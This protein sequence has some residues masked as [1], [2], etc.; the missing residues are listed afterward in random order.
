MLN[1]C[2]AI[3]MRLLC[4]L[5]QIISRQHVSLYFPKNNEICLLDN[6]SSSPS[7]LSEN[8]QFHHCNGVIA[9]RAMHYVNC[10]QTGLCHSFRFNCDKTERG[11]EGQLILFI[12]CSALVTVCSNVGIKAEVHGSNFVIHMKY[13][14][15][16]V[17]SFFT[18]L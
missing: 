10:G 15:L 14:N 8:T 4:H 1:L 18:L 13:A 6:E 7:A 5:K 3:S 2:T 12:S 17:P 9:F 16:Q 11:K